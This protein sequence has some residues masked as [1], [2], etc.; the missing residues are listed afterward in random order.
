MPDFAEIA[1]EG[2]KAFITFF[3]DILETIVV[4][5]AIFAIVYLFIASPHEVIGRSMEPNFYEGEFLLADK[6]TFRFREP[7]RGDVII[8]K[9]DDTHDYIKRVIGVP[10]DEVYVNNGE[11]Y[12]NG[13]AIEETYLPA[14][15]ET[16]NGNYMTPGRKEI[17]PE[18]TVFA[19]GDNRPH[20]SDSR[21]FGMIEADNI[22]GRAIIRYWPLGELSFIPK[23]EYNL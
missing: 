21:N 20:S 3:F 10:G 9:Y 5:F 11:V 16:A 22:K 8:F 23:P 14:G 7:E 19:L 12:I 2:P 18:G 15:L 17:V 13:E 4:A 6:I 1:K